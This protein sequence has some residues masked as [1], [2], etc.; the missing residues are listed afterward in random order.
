MKWTYQLIMPSIHTGLEFTDGLVV[1]WD[2]EYTFTL[3]T[4]Q[5]EDPI[6]QEGENDGD[7]ESRVRSL[8]EIHDSVQALA[9]YG[10][11]ERCVLLS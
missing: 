7:R 10:R 9:I 11:V 6:C 5:G 8:L 3:R 1:T 2:T 4:S